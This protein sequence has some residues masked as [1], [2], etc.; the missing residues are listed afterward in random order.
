MATVKMSS[1]QKRLLAGLTIIALILIAIPEAIRLGLV[2]N[3]QQ[4]GLER[5][6]IEDID[7]NLFTGQLGLNNVGITQQGSTALQLEMVELDIAWLASLMGDITIERMLIAGA[8]LNISQDQQGQWLVV[9]PIAATEKPVEPEP[10]EKTSDQPTL[11]SIAVADLNLRN[12]NITINSKQLNG[13]LQLEQLA[14]LNF[15]TTNDYPYSL[16]INAQWNNAP[17]SISSTGTVQN[18]QQDSRG[19]IKLKDFD[20][21][22]L[23]PLVDF[24]LGG[25]L[26]M[27]IDLDVQRTAAGELQLA[28]ESSVQLEQ[29]T[30][31][32]QGL[33]I[34][35]DNSQWQGDITLSLQ[36]S[37]LNYA[38][39]G[40]VELE[41]FLVHDI[42][43]KTDLLGFGSLQLTELQLDQDLTVAT[44][45][46]NLKQLMGLKHKP[47]AEA[48]LSLASLAVKE[49]NYAA[50]QG[51][52]IESIGLAGLQYRA[53]IMPSGELEINTLL[54]QLQAAHAPDKK[55]DEAPSE[56]DN[57]DKNALPLV[58]GELLISDD[59]HI[60]FQDQS[61]SD[62]FTL[63]LDI[64]KIQLTHIDNTE[65]DTPINIAVKAVMGEFSTINLDGQA[66]PFAEPL[67]VSLEGDIKGVDMRAFS[68]Y[69]ENFLGYSFVQGQLNHKLKVL[70]ADNKVDAKNKLTLAGFEVAAAKN[71]KDSGIDS[72]L[73]LPLNMALDTLRDKE[74][75]I[76]LE[77]PIAGP[78]HDISVG[79]GEVVS[80]ALS[81]ALMSGATSYL[82]YAL[83]PYGMAFMAVSFVGDQLS[84][85][86]LDP[87]EFAAGNAELPASA[88][89]YLNKLGGLLEQRPAL[90]LQLC[91]S[92]SDSDKQILLPGVE[93]IDRDGNKLLIALAEE[94]SAL[95]KRQLLNRGLDAGRLFICKSQYQP[96]AIAGVTL[97]I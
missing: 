34:H 31:A 93:K 24:P 49:V 77:V 26:T 62:P 45:S 78:T 23:E 3:A 6:E 48:K 96:E 47:E 64:E 14:L 50:E 79:V 52:A 37:G 55:T 69:G 22:V 19:T 86:N 97:G 29:L 57:Q 92:A 10:T 60:S 9:V 81:K 88:P 7:L 32:M 21:A 71:A 51:V 74:G 59:S 39:A 61:L 30:A 43:L 13:T 95:I 11:P 8:V 73:T 87:I 5:L 4:L 54:A 67:T 63:Q 16:S 76:T 42:S 27:A 15:S 46:L 41:D 80:D 25:L 40:D 82:K 38:L 58:I 70:I 17:L 94:R 84:Q 83:Q 1:P 91:G 44:E 18:H 66:Q 90:T 65:P 36:E 89:D 56:T 85:I 2:S 75:K 12:I 20:L 33:K 72:K 53:L 35:G 68:P 28:A